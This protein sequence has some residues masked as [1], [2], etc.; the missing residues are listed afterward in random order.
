MFSRFRFWV[1][2]RFQV[3]ACFDAN[4]CVFEVSRFRAFDVSFIR[5]LRFQ[6]FVFSM[7]QICVLM[8][9]PIDGLSR[10]HDCDV[11]GFKLLCV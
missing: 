10:S 11:C 3:F 6:V 2:L 8:R 5:C 4:M 1:C 9:F 7:F